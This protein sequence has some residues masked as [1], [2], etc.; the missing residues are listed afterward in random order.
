LWCAG[1]DLIEWLMDR[2]C[3]E[4]SR[5]SHNMPLYKVNKF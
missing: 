4:D 2:L 1:Y 3:I 5:K